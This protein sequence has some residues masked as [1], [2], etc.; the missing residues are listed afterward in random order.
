MES[1]DKPSDEAAKKSEQES[2]ETMKKLAES[3]RARAVAGEDFEKLQDEAAAAAEFKGKPPTKLGKVR[4]T[5]MP[6]DQASV[7]DLKPGESSPLI[8]MPNGYLV[9]KIGEKDTLPL[10][11]VRDEIFSTLRSQRLQQTLQK[12]Q[13]STTPQ[14]NEKYFAETPAAGSEAA[15][16]VVKPGPK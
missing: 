10:D 12:I 1:K 13:E 4:R 16:P 3:V 15:K 5:S 8:T 7:F 9:Y 2:E 6:P 11:K 14:L